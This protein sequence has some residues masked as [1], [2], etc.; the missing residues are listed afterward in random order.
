[1]AIS[2]FRIFYS[3]TFT[4]LTLVLLVLL[5]ITPGDTIYQA[6]KN[7]QYY[8]ISV[9]GGT[10]LLTLIFAILI[11]AS[12]LY[13]NRSVLAGI[14]KTWIPVE[15]SDVGK[16]V[17]RIIV[18]GLARSA[19][20]AYDAR[21]R[22]TREEKA[23]QTPDGTA[24]NSEGRIPKSEGHHPRHDG[25]PSHP[26]PRQ[27]SW[28]PISHP[29]WSSPSS[30]DLPN[31]HYESVILELPHLIEAKA[32]SLA[33]PD[34]EFVPKTTSN[35]AQ[36]AAIVP[37]ARVVEFL[38]RPA[39]MGLRDYIS[40]LTPLNLINPPNL[41][42]EFLALYEQ[43]RFSGYALTE[44]EFRTLMGTFAEILRGMK[45][46]DRAVL[47]ELQAEDEDIA[48]DPDQASSLSSAT[49]EEDEVNGA[50]AN[51]R[52]PTATARSHSGSEGTIRTALSRLPTRRREASSRSTPIATVPRTPS[53]TSL[54]R[55]RTAASST[56]STRSGASVIR[57][58]E[59]RGPLDLPYTITTTSS[60][61][62]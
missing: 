41:G 40:Y 14:P 43:A 56:A 33:P 20:I 51:N 50:G 21:P 8:Y 13:T 47:A 2:L 38:Q 1:M 49:D 28:G 37:D 19:M 7:R 12:R 30:H 15:K 24:L 61:E 58:A 60:A 48:D 32:V 34:P 10:Y 5:L 55:I 36:P 31:L 42:A 44:G 46:L 29:G 53:S 11:Y 17:R 18:E 3:T 52:H 59:A 57:L 23:T 25:A 45:E 26:L 39:T 4:I 35:D 27:P 6:Y 16:S 22:N 62:T 54:T 9:I